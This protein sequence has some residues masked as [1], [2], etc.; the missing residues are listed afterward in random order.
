M[1]DLYPSVDDLLEQ[2]VGSCGVWQWSV[3]I[4]AMFSIVVTTNFPVFLNTQPYQRCYMGNRWESAFNRSNLN[5][6][7]ITRLT[8]GGDRTSN[9]SSHTIGCNQYDGDWGNSSIPE[10]LNERTLWLYI[11]NSTN[12]T[13]P[14]T[15]G[16]VFQYGDFQYQGGMPEEFQLVCDRAEIIPIGTSLFVIGRTVGFTTGGIVASRF[17]RKKTLIIFGFCE[18][19]SS[20]LGS[21]V[22]DYWLFSFLRILVALGGSVKLSVFSVLILELTVPRFRSMFSATY[23]LGYNCVSRLLL[24]LYAYLLPDWRWLNF[25]ASGQMFLVFFYFMLPE[26]PRWLFAQNRPSDGIRVLQL[27]RRLNRLWRAD[28]LDSSSQTLDSLLEKF[29]Q[30]SGE[31]LKKPLAGSNHNLCVWEQF[32]KLISTPQ[33]TRTIV[34]AVIIFGLYAYTF[35]GLSLYTRMVKSSVFLSVLTNGLLTIPGVLLA[36]LAYRLVRH[37][38]LPLFLV[39]FSASIILFLGGAYTYIVQPEQDTVMTVTLN[40]GFMLY[41][42]VQS[43]LF[44]YIPELYTSDIRSQAFGMAAGLG[45]VATFGATYTNHLDQRKTHALPVLIYAAVTL[46]GA[47]MVLGLRDTTG[48]DS[49]IRTSVTSSTDVSDNLEHS[50]CPPAD[51]I[52]QCDPCELVPSQHLDTSAWT[53][54]HAD[55]HF[56]DG[57]DDRYS[58]YHS[59]G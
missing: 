37:R 48:E 20:C 54:L 47:F 43:M 49:G 4:L 32:R 17:G 23:F 27:G 39:F 34:L 38:R 53:K 41:T 29:S 16:Y 14:C 51:V 35:L 10:V 6:Y 40:L 52:P 31:D 28:G 18:L 19:I 15:N 30:P 58:K 45:R 8:G 13:I 59:A 12:K 55:S 3:V 46:I 1:T 36:L 33:Q 56:H 42:S 9:S 26:S 5:F 57:C 2:E 11:K 24:T 50:D 25:A 21:L 44:V 22:N 7:Q